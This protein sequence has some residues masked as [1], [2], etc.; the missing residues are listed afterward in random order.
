MHDKQCHL[1][2]MHIKEGAS[3]VAGCVCIN[4][5]KKNYPAGGSFA[6][7]NLEQAGVAKE[8]GVGAAGGETSKYSRAIVG[9]GIGKAL[10]AGEGGHTASSVVVVTHTHHSMA[11]VV[12]RAR[13]ARRCVSRQRAIDG[14]VRILLLQRASSR[15]KGVYRQLATS[16]RSIKFQGFLLCH[17]MMFF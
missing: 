2:S 11:C 5:K 6:G 15:R 1:Q 14:S 13:G 17:R 9:R 8:E 3:R 4:R 12:T 16:S 10:A 7:G